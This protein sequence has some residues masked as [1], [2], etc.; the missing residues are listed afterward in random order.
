MNQVNQTLSDVQQPETAE[1][2]TLLIDS[3]LENFSASQDVV[4]MQRECR[5]PS[6]PFQELSGTAG[7]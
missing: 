4:V 3:F 7:C 2:I 6:I 5:G 1:S